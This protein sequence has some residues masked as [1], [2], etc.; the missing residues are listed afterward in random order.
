ME[1]IRTTTLKRSNSIEEIARS[2]NIE[3]VKITI[4]PLL[5]DRV[6]VFVFQKI[7][8]IAGDGRMVKEVRLYGATRA[9]AQI[10]LRHQSRT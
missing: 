10:M 1:Y 9:S 7:S 8:A 6:L 2:T 3:L 5:I 4:D